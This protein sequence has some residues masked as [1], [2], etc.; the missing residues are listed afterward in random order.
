LAGGQEIRGFESL[1]PDRDRRRYLRRRS[2]VL[3]LIS[4]GVPRKPYCSRSRRSRKRR[5]AASN[6][7]VVNKTKRG[8]A[9][10]GCVANS[11]YGCLPPRTGGGVA[12]MRS[13]RNAFSSAV[14]TRVSHPARAS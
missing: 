13:P 6:G 11:T 8:G 9:T 4:I 7:P 1:R 10:P 14:G 12:A 2:L 3:T 5:Y